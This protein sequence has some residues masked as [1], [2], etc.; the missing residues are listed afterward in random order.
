MKYSAIYRHV[1]LI[2]F[3]KGELSFSRTQKK[4]ISRTFLK[5]ETI[6]A[7]GY[8]INERKY[9]SNSTSHYDEIFNN[10]QTRDHFLSLIRP[11]HPK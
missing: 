9:R 5:N 11:L 6:L 2:Y 1:I 4:R 3:R 7:A 8:R 10:L